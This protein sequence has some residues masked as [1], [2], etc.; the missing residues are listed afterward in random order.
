MAHPQLRRDRALVLAHRGGA[1]LRPENTIAAFDRALELG[2]DGLELDVRLSRDGEVVVHHDA[3][4]DRTTSGRGPVA[5][6]D[7]GE[8]AGLDAGARFGAADGFPFR[9][10]GLGVPRLAEVLARYPGVPMI[11]EMKADSEALAEATVREVLAAGAGAVVAFGSFH[12]RVQRVVRTLAPDVP[13][14]A[15]RPEVR[16]AL[17][18]LWVGWPI[19]RAPYRAFQVPERSGWL[20]VVSPRFVRAA[21]RGGVVVQVWTVNDEADM[22]RLLGWGVDALITDRPDLGVRVRN[23][24]GRTAEGP[25]NAHGGT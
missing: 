14:S 19:R 20:R 18:G 17:Y 22:R 9:G 15:A 12:R 8:L 4:V 6:L 5:A 2:A 16:L 7:A 10:R 23:A 21:H 3:T 13:S 24:H 11:V 25:R 1:A